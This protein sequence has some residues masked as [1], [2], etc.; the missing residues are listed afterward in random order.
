MAAPIH[1]GSDPAGPATATPEI[2]SVSEA[3]AEAEAGAD[4]PGHDGRPTS[5]PELWGW[6]S[7]GIASEVF[8]VCA[9]GSFLPVVLERLARERGVLRADG[10]TRCVGPASPSASPSASDPAPA[11]STTTTTKEAACVV[12]VAGLSVDSASFA[13][14]TVAAA[15]LVQ[16]LVLIS[17]GAVAD[18]GA[19]RRS[20]PPLSQRII[21]LNVY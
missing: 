8:A 21:S 9:V 15:V 6:Y 3:E 2:E 14:Y 5:R 16:L 7:Y 12:D 13:M 18:H 20:P 19:S 1:P 11:E 17:V 4:Y 10:S